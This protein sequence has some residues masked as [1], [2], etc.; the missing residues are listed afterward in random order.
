[1]NQYYC[2][3]FPCLSK[4][5]GDLQSSRESR[6]PPHVPFRAVGVLLAVVQCGGNGISFAA[7]LRRDHWGRACVLASLLA[8]TVK[9]ELLMSCT[10]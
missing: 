8:F 6:T 4:P 10:C 1:M 9:G 7:A 5:G 3:S 2:S